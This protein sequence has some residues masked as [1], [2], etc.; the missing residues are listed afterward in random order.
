MKLLLRE[1]KHV[2][3][4]IGSL[5]ARENEMTST[6]DILGNLTYVLLAFSYWTRDILWLRLLTVPACLCGLLFGLFFEGG[7]IWVVV[8]WNSVFLGIN[9]YQLAVIAW[10]ASRKPDDQDLQLLVDLLD[11]SD[12]NLATQAF[13]MGELESH[14]VDSLI[15]SEGRFGERLYFLLEGGAVISKSDLPVAVCHSPSLLGDLSYVTG[16]AASADA[17]VQEGSRTLSWNVN[18]LKRM[19]QEDQKLEACFSRCFSREISRKL[20]DRENVGHSDACH[21]AQPILD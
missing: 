17:V 21:V 14:E 9:A 19:F 12:L 8:F 16:R 10:Q 13:T 6:A 4:F 11:T 20:L 2:L 5:R 7:P 15:I 3:D 18:T 1:F